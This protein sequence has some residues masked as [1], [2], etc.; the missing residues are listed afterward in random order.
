MSE[1]CKWPEC[2]CFSAQGPRE[3]RRER[4]STTEAGWGD[5]ERVEWLERE[6]FDVTWFEGGYNVWR[7]DEEYIA[8]TLRAAIDAAR[9]ATSESATTTATPARNETGITNAHTPEGKH[10]AMKSDAVINHVAPVLE[11]AE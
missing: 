9:C 4:G 10:A 1:R 3:C 7:G 2:Q 8:P 11:E 5:A 6:R